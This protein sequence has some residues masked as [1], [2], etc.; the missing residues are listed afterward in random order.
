[1]TDLKKLKELLELGRNAY[2]KGDYQKAEQYYT[3]SIARGPQFVLIYLRRASVYC[4]MRNA[5]MYKADLQKF[6]AAKLNWPKINPI[7]SGF[8]I[9]SAEN[10]MTGKSQ[11]RYFY[12]KNR[13][14]FYYKT[15][16]DTEPISAICLED[17]MIQAGD[18]KKKTFK[19]DHP[20]RKF[21]FTAPSLEDKDDWIKAL[22][23]AI[24]EDIHSLDIIQESALAKESGPIMEGYLYKR[25]GKNPAWKYRYFRLQEHLLTYYQSKDGEAKGVIDLNNCKQAL[26]ADTNEAEQRFEFKIITTGRTYSLY[27]EDAQ[28]RADWI[29][30]ISQVI[31]LNPQSQRW[32]TSAADNKSTAASSSPSPNFPPHSPMP[33]VA[34]NN[35]PAKSMLISSEVK[36]ELSASN[37]ASNNTNIASVSDN[38]QGQKLASA[39]NRN[40]TQGYSKTFSGFQRGTSPPPRKQNTTSGS[41]EMAH[42]EPVTTISPLQQRELEEKRRN[43]EA[44]KKKQQ[45]QTS[46]KSNVLQTV[47]EQ[48]KEPLLVDVEA[49]ETSN[50]PTK[51]R[52]RI[53]CCQCVV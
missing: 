6:C 30:A 7:K 24:K 46:G 17:I 23:L 3:E 39:T 36:P 21:E 40:D 50:T 5:N 45:L 10:K 37:T 9:K 18:P 41:L 16:H 51:N 28:M 14:L 32:H 52:K 33:S 15:P 27:A 47:E 44:L 31:A 26:I 8:L 4:Q 13:F 35:S 20:F 29:N 42:L 49:K 48:L 12:L 43:Q 2:V 53:L 22:L 1:M 38:E 25:G 19:I 11:N 34:S